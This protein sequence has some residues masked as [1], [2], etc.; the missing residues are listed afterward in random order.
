[1]RERESTLRILLIAGTKLVIYLISAKNCTRKYQNFQ[2]FKI[3][4]KI[5]TVKCTI[6]E[7]C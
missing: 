7:I 4:K 2:N 6:S 1:M 3:L 5:A